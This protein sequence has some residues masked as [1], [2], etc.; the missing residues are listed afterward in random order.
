MDKTGGAPRRPSRSTP[1][2]PAEVHPLSPAT[3]PAPAIG[4]GDSTVTSGIVQGF[5][6]KLHF[7][8]KRGMRCVTP[9][10]FKP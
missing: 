7:L 2:E 1:G 10:V 8:H 5:T 4:T 6:G 3:H 9:L